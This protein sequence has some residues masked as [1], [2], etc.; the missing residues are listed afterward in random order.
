GRISGVKKLVAYGVSLV[1]ELPFSHVKSAKAN[2]SAVCGFAA[3]D[4]PFSVA[5]GGPTGGGVAL[6]TTVE[7]GAPPLFGVTA[8]TSVGAELASLRAADVA[9]TLPAGCPV[10]DALLLVSSSATRC[11]HSSM[12]SSSNRSR[13]VSGAGASILGGLVLAASL[14]PSPSANSR[15]AHKVHNNMIASGVTIVFRPSV[16]ISLSFWTGNAIVRGI[17]ERWVS[18]SARSL[19]S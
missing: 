16:R 19:P 17:Y 18:S 3:P 13:S 15:P 7:T 12:R 9:G 1:R 2:G 5:C 14:F 8:L 6:A 4:L 10:A 11:S